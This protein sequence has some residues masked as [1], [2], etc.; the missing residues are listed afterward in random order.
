VHAADIRNAQGTCLMTNLCRVVG[1]TQADSVFSVAE[2]MGNIPLQTLENYVGEA[3]ASQ[4]KAA[5]VEKVEL[6]HLSPLREVGKRAE[7]LADNGEL[8]DGWQ[9][10][11]N[12]SKDEANRFHFSP[13][14]PRARSAVGQPGR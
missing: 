10:M 11:K 1:N 3:C 9:S 5:T 7:L 13:V 14:R 4:G 6:R 12:D 8:D 2:V